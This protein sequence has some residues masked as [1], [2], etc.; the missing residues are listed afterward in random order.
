MRWQITLLLVV[1]QLVAHVATILILS[2][3]IRSE[4]R[5]Q[6]YALE[7][8]N[9]LLVLVRLL[10]PD[11]TSSHQVVQV[12]VDADPRFSLRPTQPPEISPSLGLV[13]DTLAVVAPPDWTDRLLVYEAHWED[14]IG[15]RGPIAEVFYLAIDL[16]DGQQLVFRPEMGPLAATIPRV[17]LTLG[18]MLIAMPIMIL[19]VWAGNMIVRP[20]ARLADGADTFAN[21]I[22][23]PHIAVGG[24]PEVRRAARSVNAMRDRIGR[25]LKDRSL[26]L[27]A[28]SHD[29]RTPLTRM[30]LRLETIEGPDVGDIVADLG[31]LE[32]MIDDA[33]TFLRA[34][35]EVSHLRRTDLAVLC[36]TVC[37][38]FAD[39]GADVRYHGPA[40][41]VSDCDP[42]LMRRVLQ[43]TVGNAVRHAGS[44]K[45]HLS[46]LLQGASNGVMVEVVDQGPGIA[47]DQFET[48]LRPFSRLQAVEAGGPGSVGG[49]GLGLAIAKQL[50][51]RQNGALSLHGNDPSG[52]I[53]R[54]V[55][56]TPGQAT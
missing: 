21:D 31:E 4:E 47:P 38:E 55:L 39:E 28:I 45:L 43:N 36:K 8:G 2:P 51:A 12:I 7:L 42:A 19:A 3:T 41:L 27:A 56:A 11:A 32:R 17:V 53:V 46:G 44:A 9:P 16:E 15:P 33:L 30:R 52:L 49:F 5:Q 24:A 29:M 6:A 10:P 40:H 50:M 23:A 18:L 1:T 20:I 13:R 25:L 54:M 22:N 37:D 34:E 48:V 35:E 26:T 14:R